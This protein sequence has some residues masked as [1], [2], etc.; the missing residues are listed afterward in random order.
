MKEV[1][2]KGTQT[3]VFERLKDYTDFKYMHYV[4]STN[5]N[6]FVQ[7]YQNQIEKVVMNFGGFCKNEF[8]AICLGVYVLEISHL[9]SIGSREE[10]LNNQIKPMCLCKLKPI[11]YL[12]LS[13]SLS[14]YKYD[15][16]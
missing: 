1:F 8:E 3:N 11:I 9:S 16:K 4:D 6:H 14:I 13:I 7:D 5:Q 15:L 12:L 2:E 10:N